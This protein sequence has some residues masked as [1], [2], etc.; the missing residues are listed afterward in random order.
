MLLLWW[1]ILFSIRGAEDLLDGVL[2]AL[3]LVIGLDHLVHAD[4]SSLQC[5]KA[6]NKIN[7]FLLYRYAS[8]MIKRATFISRKKVK[9][10]NSVADPEAGSKLNFFPPSRAGIAHEGG[11]SSLVTWQRR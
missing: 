6:R 1:C 4:K 8:N 11:N 7:F 3:A 5:V 2:C 9:G 10:T